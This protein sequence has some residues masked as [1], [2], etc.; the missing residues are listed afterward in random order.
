MS[1][2]DFEFLESQ[3]RR[4]DLTNAD[5]KN[6]YFAL[7]NACERSRDYAR[8]FELLLECNRLRHKEIDYDIARDKNTCAKIKTLFFERSNGDPPSDYARVS[9]LT[10]IFIV[11]MPRSGTSLVEQIIASHS[12]VYG[13]RELARLRQIIRPII[14][15][16]ADADSSGNNAIR[17]N[18]IGHKINSDYLG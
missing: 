16:A 15:A 4:I 7:A 12:Q 2:A 9:S 6:Y 8:H 18:N 1:D 13:A 3:I 17:R 14:R 11:G 5:L 10:P